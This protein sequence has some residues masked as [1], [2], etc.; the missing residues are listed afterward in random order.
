MCMLST[1]TSNMQI[2]SLNIYDVRRNVFIIN[3]LSQASKFYVVKQR[4]LQYKHILKRNYKNGNGRA[5][6]VIILYIHRE[7]NPMF[8]FCS[9][10]TNIVTRQNNSWVV[11]N[12]IIIALTQLL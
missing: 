8:L 4:H 1:H 9:M 5:S 3:C 6:S 12:S 7:T 2:Y 11:Q 10:P